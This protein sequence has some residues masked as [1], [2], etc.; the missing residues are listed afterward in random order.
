MNRWSI[1][2]NIPIITAGIVSRTFLNLGIDRFVDACR[3][4]HH[5]AYGYNSDRDD[6]MLL[7]K[8]K[9]GSCTTKHAVIGTLAKELGLPIHKNIGIYPMNEAIVTGTDRILT[10]FR[11]PYL[12]MV[13]CFLV[14]EQ[15]RIDLTEGNHNGKNGPVQDF[16]YT[17]VVEAD[18]SGKIEYLIYRRAL[19]EHILYRNEFDGVEIKRILQARQEG[20]A[21]LKSLV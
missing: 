21:L 18:I 10:Q 16:L 12:P 1:P 4:V 8:E 17:E 15:T 13:H 20:L 14:Y 3:F 9:K 19:T 2:P 5:L 7:F 11:L 6:M